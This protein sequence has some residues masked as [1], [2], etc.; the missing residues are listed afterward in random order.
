MSRSVSARV[1]SKVI[2]IIILVVV[3][4]L[5]PLVLIEIAARIAP[6]L[7][8]TEIK[9]VFQ[10][11]QDQPL[12]GLIPDG[13]LGY[14]YASGLK[15]FPVPFVGDKAEQVYT[16]TTVSLGYA[17]VGFRDDGLTGDPF[18][19]VVG[20]S[21]A[22]CAS[23]A[24]EECWVELLEQAT[25]RD[26]ANLGVV[27]YSPQQTQ[28]MLATYGLPLK[29]KLVLWVF[30]GND[31]NDAWRFDQFGSGAAREG[32]FWQQPVR[33]WLARNSVVYQALS[34]F[35]YNRDLFTRLAQADGE[36]V[37]RDSNLIWWLTYTDLTV[38]EVAAGLKLTE[39]A[40]LTASEQLRAADDTADFVVVILPF[41]EQ[42]YAAPSLRPQLDGY[43]QALLDFGRQ[44]DIT[45]LDLTP[46]LRE[47]A[48]SQ[49]T[50]L[51]FQ[52]DIHLNARGNEL[53]AQLLR[54][55]LSSILAK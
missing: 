45:V 42:V 43:S 34:F 7:I 30:F 25:G 50:P 1:K 11:E 38:P 53:V 49:P 31:L 26:F 17:G 2:S 32:K 9:A 21:Y 35:W 22:N 27:G 13:Q 14:K 41:R 54:Q 24:L 52:Q 48:A 51:Y 36:L 8:P 44:H 5:F 23:V 39:T 40:I 19:V 33:A 4:L 18:A 12:K 3:G 46:A 29:P 28:R 16:V 37:P 55:K 10:H 47:A 6:Q 20:D 15:N